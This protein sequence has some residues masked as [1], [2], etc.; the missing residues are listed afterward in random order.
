MKDRHTTRRWYRQVLHWRCWQSIRPLEMN[1]WN[2]SNFRRSVDS[3][4]L[5][6]LP[7]WAIQ[8]LPV[9]TAIAQIL[10]RPKFLWSSCLWPEALTTSP[11]ALS[12]TGDSSVSKFFCAISA[13]MLQ[14]RERPICQAADVNW[15]LGQIDR[16][17]AQDPQ[18]YWEIWRTRN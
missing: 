15:K 18:R 14:T 3:Q 1:P 13:D 6:T 2:Q 5:T 16:S 12:S 7:P 10:K 9:V 8:V 11:T 17:K 4:I